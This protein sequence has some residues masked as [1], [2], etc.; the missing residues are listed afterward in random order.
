MNFNPRDEM[1]GTYC[2]G[3]GLLAMSVILTIGFLIVKGCL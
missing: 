2:I 3:Y 1:G